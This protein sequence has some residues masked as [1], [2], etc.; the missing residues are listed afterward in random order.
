MVLKNFSLSVGSSTDLDY[1]DNTFDFVYS[2]GVIHHSGN[3]KKSLKEIY[4]VL[5]KG[6]TSKIMIYNKNSLI[7]F[8]YWIYYSIIEFNFKKT[9]NQII[10]EK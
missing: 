8:V 7:V 6:G 4:R 3:I 1:S 5:K 9:R 10:E 2:W